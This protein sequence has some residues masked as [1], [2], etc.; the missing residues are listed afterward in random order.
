MHRS[1]HGL[2]D[3]CKFGAISAR[4]KILVVDAR[5][6][7]NNSVQAAQIDVRLLTKFTLIICAVTLRY[8]ALF[9]SFSLSGAAISLPVYERAGSETRRRLSCSP[10][11]QYVPWSF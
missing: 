4:V 6:P 11:L 10:H 5:A 7:D 8:V 2:P 1:G 9:L 3:A